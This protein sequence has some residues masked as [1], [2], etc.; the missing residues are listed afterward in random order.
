MLREVALD[1][2]LA[3]ARAAGDRRLADA[4]L[5][6]APP[7]ALWG[8]RPVTRASGTCLDV[9]RVLRVTHGAPA[10]EAVALRCQAVLE[11]LRGRMDAARR[12]IGS[13]HRTVDRL[14]LAHRRIEADVAAGY[15]ELLDGQPEAAEALLRGA[16][17][18]LRARGLDGEAA[19]AAAFLG[20][21][22]LLQDRVD[23]A[24]AVATEGAELAGSDLKAAIAWRDVRAE[25][26]AR[27][28]DV[29][30]ARS[31]AEEAVSLAAATDALLLVADARLTLATVLYL[32]GDEAAAEAEAQRAVDACEAKGATALLA[33]LGA[34]RPPARPSAPD[35]ATP[36]RP[37]GEVAAGGG[38]LAMAAALRNVEACNRRDFA[39]VTSTFTPRRLIRRPASPRGSA[40]RG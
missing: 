19:Q 30:R 11:A 27:R 2:A 9:I 10:V 6:E 39:A 21:A 32:A 29:D 34:L 15:I 20:R 36:V 22:L 33:R 31:L 40:V 16:Y 23:E 13:A 7:A 14:G 37:T 1:A 24:D 8:P 28:G 4:I 12:M 3:A 35:V 38:R 25:A 26:A 17:D 5:A 18:E